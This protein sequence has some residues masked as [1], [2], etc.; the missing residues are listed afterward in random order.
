MSLNSVKILIGK[1]I[2]DLDLINYM[3]ITILKTAKSF[4]LNF[5]TK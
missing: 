2:A 5:L 3:K 1:S 4:Y